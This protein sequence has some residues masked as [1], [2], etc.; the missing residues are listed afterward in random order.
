MPEGDFF[1]VGK[2]LEEIEGLDPYVRST[3]VTFLR[4]GQDEEQ[5]TV[6]LTVNVYDLRE[7]NAK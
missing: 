2:F 6:D 1:S 7:V 4:A 3:E 5:L